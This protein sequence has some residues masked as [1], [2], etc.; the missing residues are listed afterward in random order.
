M[1]TAYDAQNLILYVTISQVFAIFLVPFYRVRARLTT[2][3]QLVRVP[4]RE[5]AVPPS[6][7]RPK[8]YIQSQNDL[9]QVNQFVK[10][11]SPLGVVSLML[12][13]GQLLATVACVVGAMV[14]WPVSWVEENVLRTGKGLDRA[15]TDV[16]VG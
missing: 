14:G 11:L 6:A 7:T 12:L 1:T 5:P 4:P 13:V 2:V 10:F 9:Y 3:L 15:V 8:F 16:L